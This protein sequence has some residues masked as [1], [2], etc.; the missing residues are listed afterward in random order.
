MSLNCCKEHNFQ[1]IVYLLYT[2]SIFTSQPWK[3]LVCG[4]CPPYD[5]N[6]ETSPHCQTNQPTQIHFL[7]EWVRFDYILLWQVSHCWIL[8]WTEVGKAQSLATVCHL[9][10]ITELPHEYFLPEHALLC[11]T[12]TLLQ[13]PL[14]SWILPLLFGIPEDF[15]LW[16]NAL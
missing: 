9:D 12:R 3:C 15:T 1:H 13:E 2:L 16:G 14:C 6:S 10:E 8:T 11:S 5:L 4:K 7:F